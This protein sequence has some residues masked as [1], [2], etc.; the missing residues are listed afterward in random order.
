MGFCAI[1]FNRRCPLP[2]AGGLELGN[3]KGPFQPRS[4]YDFFKK[5]K[6]G[7]NKEYQI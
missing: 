3:L 1:G 7:K 4:F 5:E 6:K 2:I